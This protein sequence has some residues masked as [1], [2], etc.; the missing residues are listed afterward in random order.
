MD[1]LSGIELLHQ[2]A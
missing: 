2:S 1:T